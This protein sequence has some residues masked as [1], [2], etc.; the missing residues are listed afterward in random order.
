MMSCL[1]FRLLPAEAQVSL[2][3]KEGVYLGKRRAG[4]CV[5]LLYQMDHF[6]VEL[7]YTVYRQIINNIRVVDMMTVLDPYLE[8]IDVEDL[9]NET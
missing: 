4:N 7:K 5:I 1:E 6:Y 8:Q 2:L 9:V 3:Y